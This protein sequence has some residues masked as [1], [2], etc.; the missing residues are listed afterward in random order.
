MR[1]VAAG[2]SAGSST[3]PSATAPAAHVSASGAR[4]RSASGRVDHLSRRLSRLGGRVVR[5]LRAYVSPLGWL[6]LALAVASLAGFAAAGWHELL[7]AGVVF[8]TMLLAAV[9][10]SLGNTGFGA[11]LAVSDRRVRV[12]DHVRVDV[13]VENPGHAPTVRARGELPIGRLREAFAIPMLG[14][15]QSKRTEVEFT[16]AARA[17]LKVGPLNVRKGDPFGL[18]RHE[19]SLSKDI[20]MYIHPA[21]VPLHGLD[22]GVARDLDGQPSGQIV[23]DDL[24]FYGLREYKPGD[25]LRN[26]HWLSTARTGT[27]M[28]RQFNAARRTDTSLTLDVAPADYIDEA[29]FELAVSIHASIG[30][31]CL[32]QDRPLSVRAG[33]RFTRPKLPMAFLDECSAITPD[34]DDDPNL[35]SMTLRDTPDASFYYLTVGSLKDT[36]SIRRV[37]GAL[38]RSATSVVLQARRG[39]ARSIRR[40]PDFT[41]ATVGSLEDL[42]AIMEAMS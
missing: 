15:G 35:A 21:T 37:A 3:A 10:M 32:A 11:S 30:A 38:P 2:P 6:A 42:P 4:R 31:Q 33:N 26:V 5:A 9:A 18:I 36:D 13:N 8:A 17:V 7:A 27:M 19:K 14:P 20:T 1:S 39:A 23:D 12:G 34:A 25:D 28:I 22:A 40:F 16:A 29:E 41:L 24:D